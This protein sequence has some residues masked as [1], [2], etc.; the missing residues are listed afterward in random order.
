[1]TARRARRKFLGYFPDG[2]RDE[3]YLAWER[4]YKW[5]AHR[6]WDAALNRETF[7]RL[8]RDGAHAEIAATAVRIE[9]RTNL[10]FSF[11]KM[12]LRDAVAGA[13]GAEAFA[14]GLYD[15]LW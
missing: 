14:D 7:R 9:A 3:S 4:D 12:A 8:R 11:E 1:M 15:W 10:L 5:D 2:F 13:D 6:A